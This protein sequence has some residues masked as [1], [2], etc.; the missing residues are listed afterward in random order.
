MEIRC[1]RD[2][3]AK[4]EKIRWLYMKNDY[5]LVSIVVQAYNSATTIVQTLDSIKNQ[6]YPNMELIITDDKSIDNTIDICSEWL[7]KNKGNFVD[8][9]LIVS[10]KNTGLSG[11]NNRALKHVKGKYVEFLAADDYMTSDAIYEY[12]DFCEKNIDVVPISRLELFSDETRDFTE[13]EKYCRNCYEF[14]KLNQKEQL[15]QLLIQNRIAAPAASFYP[16][17]I[18]KKCNGFDEEYRIMEDY[19][20][21]LKILF[22]GYKFGFIDKKLIYYRI[23]GGSITGSSM[24]ELKKNEAK[25]FFRK[26]F[27]YMLRSNMCWEAIKQS[28]SW[29][30]FYLKLGKK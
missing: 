8:V 11:N 12:V 10:D 14:A 13:A 18:L 23:S 7:D 24:L 22:N 25:L 6:T 21:N 28:R 30:K 16:I 17:K 5:E 27:W 26:K 4:F 19:P 1:A 15:R 29:I 3:Y 2:I 20:I 9:K